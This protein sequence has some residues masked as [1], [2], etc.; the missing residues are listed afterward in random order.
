MFRALCLHGRGANA[1]VRAESS[2]SI[3]NCQTN[4]T[5]VL[6]IQLARLREQ[7]DDVVE[8]DFFEGAETCP[9]DNG[10]LSDPHFSQSML[11]RPRQTLRPSF[12]LV[13]NSINIS[14]HP[15]PALYWSRKP[16]WSNL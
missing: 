7:L 5:K 10:I 11:T 13:V 2:L 9:G 8:F 1:E 3:S 6:E 14:R 4:S 16:G 12:L 15:V